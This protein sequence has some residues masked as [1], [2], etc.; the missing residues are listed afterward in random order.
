VGRAQGGVVTAAATRCLSLWVCCGQPPYRAAHLAWPL[1]VHLRLPYSLLLL[2]CVRGRAVEEEE[3]RDAIASEID[4]L[5]HTRGAIPGMSERE[6]RATIRSLYKKAE[7]AGIGVERLDG[8]GGGGGGGAGG[9]GHEGADSEDDD[10]DEDGDDE[11]DDGGEAVGRGGAERM[12]AGARAIAAVD[13]HADGDMGSEGEGAGDSEG[14]E[15]EDG[16]EG[17]DGTDEAPPA[18]GGASGAKG[19]ALPSGIDAVE[20]PVASLEEGLRRS[21]EVGSILTAALAEA[22]R[23]QAVMARSGSGRK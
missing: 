11:L 6:R 5:E 15:E 7:D 14:D 2:P 16:G 17:D 13:G 19:T 8:G 10:A 9:A 21:D 22:K 1:V 12:D 4:V 18:A 20:R 3:L 23:R